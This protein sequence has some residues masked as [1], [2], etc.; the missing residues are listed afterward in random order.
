MSVPGIN[1]ARDF[2]ADPRID[3]GVIPEIRLNSL[4]SGERGTTEFQG[5]FDKRSKKSAFTHP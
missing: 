2:F 5:L 3:A 1:F 4:K